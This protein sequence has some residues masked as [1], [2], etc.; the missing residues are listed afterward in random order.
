MAKKR[1]NHEGSIRYMPSKKLYQARLMVDGVRKVV[2]SKSR[3]GVA[4]K[5]DEMRMSKRQGIG[6]VTKDLKLSELA[7]LW[8]DYRKQHWDTKTV[9]GYWTPMKLHILPEL[10]NKKL[11]S[12][13]NPVFLDDFFNKTLV[14]QG[15][16]AHMIGRCHRSLRNALE[17]AVGRNLIGYNKCHGG[18]QGYFQLPKHESKSKPTLTIEEVKTLSSELA[19]SKHST[20]FML[21][22]ATGMRINEVLGL[23]AEDVDFERNTIT[24]RHQLKYE[25]RKFF[26]DKTKTKI[27]RTIPVDERL[28][29]S[30][31]NHLGSTDE[32]KNRLVEKVDNNTY[33]PWNPYVSCTCCSTKKFRLIFLSDIGTPLDYNNLR[34]RH[35]NKLMKHTALNVRLTI[36]DLRHLFASI[37]LA[38]GFDVV[39]VS[40]ILGHANPSITLKVYSQYIHSP[41]Q[42]EVAAAMGNL[43]LE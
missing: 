8:I 9:E 15:K 6:L 23:S 5:L 29:D 34:D 40:K 10:A 37:S 39:T 31:L 18:K 36:H 35:W 2:Y 32:L 20:L 42:T 12:I 26:L 30:L 17:W 27:V 33:T 1:S 14:S 19:G 4:D 7:E 16:T 24:V 11:S 28:M 21:A 38:N 13:N 41:M 43:I 22:L 3:E 25:N